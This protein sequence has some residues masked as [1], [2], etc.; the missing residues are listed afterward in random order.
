MP[1]KNIHKHAHRAQENLKLDLH[2]IAQVTHFQSS[3]NDRNCNVFVSRK[4][5]TNI[6]NQA[7]NQVICGNKN[8]MDPIFAYAMQNV[9]K[10][11]YVLIRL[12]NHFILLNSSHVHQNL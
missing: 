1:Q 12:M 5:K 6:Q 9:E 2:Y 10:S 7:D 8:R 4:K 11:T 3:G